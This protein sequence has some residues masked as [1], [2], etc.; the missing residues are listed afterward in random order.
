MRASAR[1]LGDRVL[2]EGLWCPERTVLLATCFWL[3]VR[4]QARLSSVCREWRPF[5]C[6]ASFYRADVRLLGLCPFVLH[7]HRFATFGLASG[8]V[9]QWHRDLAWYFP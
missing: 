2:Q 7:N 5:R 3:S 8:A 6:P 9:V 1:R 4:E